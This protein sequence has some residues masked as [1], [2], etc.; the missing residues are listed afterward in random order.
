[1]RRPP[2]SSFPDG[3]PLSRAFVA[4]RQEPAEAVQAGGETFV[5]AATSQPDS[6][7]PR[8]ERLPVKG[9]GVPAAR[10]GRE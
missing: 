6:P 5:L 4:A 8:A 2:F 9:A 1:M 3:E 7:A 10:G